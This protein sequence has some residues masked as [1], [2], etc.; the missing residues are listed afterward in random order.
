MGEDAAKVLKRLAIFLDR[1]ITLVELKIEE[2]KKGS[3]GDG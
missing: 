1:L 3:K 2:A